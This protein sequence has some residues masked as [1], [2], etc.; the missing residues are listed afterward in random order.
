MLVCVSVLQSTAEAQRGKAFQQ[1]EP[2]P[3]RGGSGFPGFFDTHQVKSGAFALDIPYLSLWYG[4]SD[5]LSIGAN[6]LGIISMVAEQSLYYAKLRYR[7]WSQ[8]S[9]VSTLSTRIGYAATSNKYRSERFGFGSVT[10]STAISESWGTIT[11]TVTIGN[12]LANA[13][14]LDSR[15]MMEVTEKVRIRGLLLAGSYEHFF[16]KHLGILTT[17]GTAPVLLTEIDNPSA[18]LAASVNDLGGIVERSFGRAF[19]QLRLGKWLLGAGM[20]VPLGA[21][22]EV[23][24]W[25]ILQW[26]S[27]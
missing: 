19:L 27:K 21:P 7:L 20:V 2:V 14:S 15:F 12:L 16:T 8:D 18:T 1:D 10:S 22:A 25:G 24:P 17:L 6:G 3:A 9:M 23:A 4:L 11:G 5:K 13:T 26:K